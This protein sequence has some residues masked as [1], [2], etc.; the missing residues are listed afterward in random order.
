M[1]YAIHVQCKFSENELKSR[2]KHKNMRERAQNLLRSAT[3]SRKQK[4]RK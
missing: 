4:M 1:R 3:D 2:A